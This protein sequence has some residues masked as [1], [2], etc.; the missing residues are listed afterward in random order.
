MALD[1]GEGLVAGEAPHPLARHGD[2]FAITAHDQP[3]VAAHQVAV[4]DKAQR[5]GR[6][7][8]RAKIFHRSDAVFVA[9]VEHDLFPAN[10]PAQGLL[11]DFVR[12]A[13]DVPGVFR[14]H[15]GPP[16]VVVI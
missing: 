7:A 2:G 14:V 5:Q 15:G 3:V 8:V 1:H 11:G 4:F 12:G 16:I 9:T 10:L 6:A 13:G